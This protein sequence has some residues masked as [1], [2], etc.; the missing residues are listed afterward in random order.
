[1]I[2]L[3]KRIHQLEGHNQHFE[4]CESGWCNPSADCNPAR[5]MFGLHT[6]LPASPKEAAGSEVIGALRHLLTF[7]DQGSDGETEYERAVIRARAAI[8]Q[9]PEAVG[10]SEE[11]YVP[12]KKTADAEMAKRAV[13]AAHP[14]AYAKHVCI[15]NWW[16]MSLATGDRCLGNGHRQWSAWE[17]AAQ[18]LSAPPSGEQGQEGNQGETPTCSTC[19]YPPAECVCSYP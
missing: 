7:C 11:Q 13:L 17:D 19:G 12:P 4:R 2:G 18:N 14:T 1:M 10:V 6:A 15:A 5:G 3:R 8:S 9:V 16:I